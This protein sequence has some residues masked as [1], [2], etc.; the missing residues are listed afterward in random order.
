[1]LELPD[2]RLTEKVYEGNQT[3]IYRGYGHQDNQ[4]YIIKTFKD[5]YPTPKQIAQLHHEFEITQNLDLPN[6]VKSIEIQQYEHSWALIFEDD[7]GD[8]LKNILARQ[9]V[10]LETILKIAVQLAAG[11]GQLHEHF[12]IHKDIKPG[13][14]IVNLP[15]EVVKI[16]D[17]SIASRLSLEN[18]MIKNP[19]LL[20]GTLTYISPEQSGRMNRVIDYRTDFYSL[21][22][23][24][25]EMLTGQPPFQAA[26]AMAL[27]HSHLAKQPTPPQAI[28]PQIPAVVSAIV[29]KLLAKTAEARY[30]SAYGLKID[31]MHCLQQLQHYQRIEP[32]KYGQHD[33]SRQLQIPQKLYGR[34]RE[35]ATLL[36][37]FDAVS[38]GQRHMML[39]AGYSGIGKT[40]LVQ[41]IYKPI[42]QK[43]GYFISGKFDQYQRNSPYS[44][45][46]NGFAQLIRQ[47]LTE[48]ESRL[49]QWRAQLLAAFGVSGQVIIEV[50]PELELIIG[51]Q[52]AVID[53]VPVEAQNRF[54][55]VFQNFIQVFSKPEHPL[56]IFLDDL[57]W[58]DAA[59]LNL[60][61]LMM[62]AEQ[63]GY[64]FLIGAYRDN[65]VDATHPLLMML[66]TLQATSA[67]IHQITLKPLSL[68]HI[69]QLLVDTLHHA[70]QN[71]APLAEL[72]IQK[73]QGNPFF[74]NQFL[75]TLYDEQLLKLTHAASDYWDWDLKQIQTQ[76]I[77]DNVVELM[78]K[79][80]KKLPTKTQTVLHLAACVGNHFNLNTLAIIYE[81]DLTTTYQDLLPGIQEELLVLPTSEVEALTQAE[82]PQLMVLNYKFLHDR[83]QQ[84]AYALI[85]AQQKPAV[86][87]KIG[88]LLLAN[89]PQAEHHE[90]I[91]EF[92]DQLNYGRSL[93]KEEDEQIELIELN[94]KA[95]QKA[96]DATAYAAALHYLQ[97]SFGFNPEIYPHLWSQHYALALTLHI[98]RAAVEYLN[99]QFEASEL[100]IQRAVTH[101]QTAL[102]KA[103]MLHM[104]IIQ[105][106]LQA[107]Y[108]QAIA[109]GRQALA[110]ID[111]DLPETELHQ[112]RDQEMHTIKTKI[113]SRSIASLFELPL[114]TDV[115]KQIAV[116]L[117][118][119][120]GPPCY[121]AHQRLWAVIVAKVIHIWLDYGHVPQVGYS[122]T[123]Y[124]GLLGYVDNDYQTGA[125]F[126]RLAQRIM[127]EKFNHCGSD[128]SVFYLMIGSSLRHWTEPLTHASADYQQA[129]QIGLA[130]GNLQYAAYAFGH[131]MYCRFYQGTELKVLLKEIADYLNFS[132]Q[133]Q[134]QWAIDLLEGGQRL[135]QQ[136]LQ[137]NDTPLETFEAEYLQR[138]E[139]H[140]NIQVIC[141]YYILKTWVCYLLGD[142]TQA[143]AS[144]F[145]ADSRLI[146]VATQGLLPS[147]Q[148]HF[149]HSLLLLTQPE[150]QHQTL[151]QQQK[152]AKIWARHC[153]QN[154]QHQYLI[155]AA[156]LAKPSAHAIHYYD[157][158]IDTAKAHHFSQYAALANELASQFW[159]SR[160]K[161]TIAQFYL[162]EAC[163]YYLLWGATQKVAQLEYRYPSLAAEPRSLPELSA[164]TLK[165]NSTQS[166]QLLDLNSV[167]KACQAISKEIV[168]SNLIQK[169]MAIVIE[170]VGAQTGILLLERQQQFWLEAEVQADNQVVT[171]LESLPLTT[172]DPKTHKP[173]LPLTLINYVLRTQHPLVLADA[174]RQ[175]L[176]TTD[177]YIV[178]HQCQSICCQPIFYQSR[179][180]GLLYLENNLISNAFTEQRLTTLELLTTQMAI[181][182]QN[183]L[184]YQQNEQARY[185]AE[186]ANRAKSTFLANMSHE[187]RTPLNG[188]LGFAQIFSRDKNLTAQQQQGVSIIQR[189]A[190]HL[191]TLLND[192][193]DISKIEAT[194]MA[195]QQQAFHFIGFLKDLVVLFQLRA[196][197]KH[198]TFIY[199]PLT[200][201]P[202]GIETDEKRL[203]QILINLLGNA[204]KFTQQGGV[205]FKVSA[206]LLEQQNNA[207]KRY[208]TIQFGIED[209]GIGI[210]EE[211]LEK[212]FQPFEQAGDARFRPDGTGL[213]LAITQKLVELMDGTLQVESVLGQ[214]SR[215]TLSFSVAEVTDFS[216]P[217]IPVEPVIV[218]YQAQQA[219]KI[220]V[221]DDK[222]E[223]RAVLVN[224]LQPLGFELYEA[225]NGLT[226]LEQV[227]TARPHLVIL[228]LVMPTMDGFELTRQLRKC[229]EFDNL[230]IIASSASVF[231]TEQQQSLAIG[232]NDFLPKPIEADKLLACLKKH[233]ELTWITDQPVA[234]TQATPTTES[235]T[236]PLA[237]LSQQ[238][239]QLLYDLAIIGDIRALIEHSKQLEAQ[240]PALQPLTQKIR[241]LAEDFE[242][243]Q[244][245]QLLKAYLDK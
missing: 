183:A 228:D 36:D 72:V 118:I 151:A 148:H 48:D 190:Q 185:Q 142:L 120:M 124:G 39:V 170:N 237:E 184:L 245:C 76:A 144:F 127:Q 143:W 117:L 11:L 173:R 89:I 47:L 66:A 103:D 239:A 43:R 168:L 58:V 204:I 176:F 240:T 186:A 226:G 60:I 40:A 235:L 3:I 96:K 56:V 38:Q 140:K 7:Q 122:H 71:V 75:R 16:A 199:E 27:V 133:H 115:E 37:T 29:M 169:M 180:M 206:Q 85:E 149:N 107:Q 174:Q 159:L 34:E 139:Q 28:D 70:P 19:Q 2:Y 99:G 62:T 32:F 134:N 218:G 195:L 138:C 147:A 172:L 82:K 14:I 88:Q 86:H 112:A 197:Q 215:F 81:H 222:W 25:Y 221:V 137:E 46:I 9:R 223:N 77:T 231:E 92:I 95:A 132:Y 126:G 63:Q 53:L 5:K 150:I 188:I 153:P 200:P 152:Q 87:L 145:Q 244:I 10:N 44:A 229:S 109:T 83:V 187:L 33:F 131:N 104:L 130:T 230:P 163:Y 165:D 166:S 242:M 101:A 194:Q 91:F 179:L 203:R 15:T 50:I 171:I 177:D 12:I 136:L 219:F 201:L 198:I 102:E 13:N 217:E 64:L 181:S 79:K 243:Q 80:L 98:E 189:N 18:Q 69:I 212:I 41:E 236:L 51:P 146:A 157:Q 155:V 164:V 191:L 156:E 100:F 21:G 17:F 30:Q 214:G 119:T 224:F 241:D 49:Q 125:E 57:Q 93:L 1:M 84:A 4:S 35:L 205:T 74:V 233:L 65:E 110:F 123:A 121:R 67:K 196:Q 45:I 211:E 216:V 193:L 114:M 209:T 141:I 22:V 23:V 182:I 128:N 213:G 167:I 113:G 225:E 59:S 52:P 78:L 175:N 6:I 111:I 105:Y 238:Q 202:V 61:Q 210:A 162:Q 192:I 55:R 26:D 108:A 208:H 97:I 31:L 178:Y 232:C 135:V 90:R 54:K 220:L 106:T 20:E 94:L 227:Q 154:F 116:K 161:E 24:F 129:Y 234:E 42:T 207:N 160:G 8:S 68:E 73:T 158:A